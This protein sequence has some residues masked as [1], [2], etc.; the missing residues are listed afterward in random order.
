MAIGTAVAFLT[1]IYLAVT[2]LPSITS[3]ILQLR[4]GA[5]PTLHDKDF[6][7]YRVAP[8]Q[9]SILTGSMFWGCLIS[10]ALVGGVIGLLVFLCLWQVRIICITL[11]I[12]RPHFLFARFQQRIASS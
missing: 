9:V 7:K 8:D 3:T 5:I 4:S 11:P 10:S 1:S 12:G 2:F 6:N